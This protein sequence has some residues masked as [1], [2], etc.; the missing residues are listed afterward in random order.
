MADA[1]TTGVIPLPASPEIA[2]L[3]D[4]KTALTSEIAKLEKMD[5]NKQGDGHDL[6]EVIRRTKKHLVEINAALQEATK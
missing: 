3:Q 4:R 6:L 5:P 1:K 2:N